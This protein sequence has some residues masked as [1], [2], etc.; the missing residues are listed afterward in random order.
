MS[1][2]IT[3]DNDP[4]IPLKKGVK[5]LI[6][7][8]LFLLLFLCNS[9]NY[10]IKEKKDEIIEKLEISKEDTTIYTILLQS[11]RIIGVILIIQ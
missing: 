11:G 9:N 4:Y 3:D 5:I 1:G 7:T 10:I 2:R 8:E 6:Y